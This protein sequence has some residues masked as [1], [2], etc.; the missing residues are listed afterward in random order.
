VRALEHAGRHGTLEAGE[1]TADQ[2]IGPTSPLRVVDAIISGT[3]EPESGHYQL[4][5]AFAGDR[6]LAEASKLLEVEGYRTHEFGD[7]VFIDKE[8]RL[9]GVRA[10]A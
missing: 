10:A 9:E 5:R 6:V 1:G 3:H 4:L 7:S 8:C 2:R